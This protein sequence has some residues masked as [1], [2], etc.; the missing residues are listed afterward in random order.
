MFRLLKGLVYLGVS[1][2]LICHEFGTNELG[3][4]HKWIPQLEKYASAQGWLFENAILL[5]VFALMVI[6]AIYVL[7]GAYFILTCNHEE[8]DKVYGKPLANFWSGLRFGRSSSDDG[9]EDNIDRLKK[10]RASK[11]SVMNNE[12]SVNEYRQTAWLDGMTNNG[13]RN[14]QNTKRYIN[15]KLSTMSNEQAYNWIKNGK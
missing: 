5:F 9:G 4:T 11:M 1:G 8:A 7:K 2:W 14:A 13:G 6:P 3:S 10:Y 12:Q 15:S